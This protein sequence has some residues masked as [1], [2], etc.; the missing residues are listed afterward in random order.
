MHKELLKK[1]G[2]LT[3]KVP[4]KILMLFGAA[5]HEFTLRY[6][7]ILIAALACCPAR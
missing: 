1:I 7:L 5:F 2:V 4:K 6:Y 3:K